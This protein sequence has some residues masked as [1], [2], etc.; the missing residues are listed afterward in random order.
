[1]PW[2]TRER[3]RSVEEAPIDEE[4]GRSRR[5]E[6]VSTGRRR[7]RSRGASAG[8]RER[9]GKDRQLFRRS[10]SFAFS[11]A[12]FGCSARSLSI[13]ALKAANGCAPFMP[14]TVLT[15]ELL[16]SVYA[17]KNAGVPVTP[18]F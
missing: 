14:V 11:C 4:G 12:A 7:G 2:R 9:Q 15:L 10:Y 1:S 16:G 3:R 5:T 18:A 13:A 8:K 17:R 6:A